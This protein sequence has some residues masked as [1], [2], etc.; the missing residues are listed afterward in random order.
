MIPLKPFVEEILRSLYH[1]DDIDRWCWRILGVFLV[2]LFLWN[3][4]WGS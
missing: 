3:L 1:G 2:G 4:I